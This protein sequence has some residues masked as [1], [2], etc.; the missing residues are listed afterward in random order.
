[1][2]FTFAWILARPPSARTL[3]VTTATYI[4]RVEEKL[5]TRCKSSG[6]ERDLHGAPGLLFVGSI[7]SRERREESDTR[8][9]LQNN[10]VGPSRRVT[11]P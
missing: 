9:R 4:P 11:R 5:H 2:V 3:V 1:M 8:P 10:V 7:W 6:V